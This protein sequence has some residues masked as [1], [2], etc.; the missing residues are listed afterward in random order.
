MKLR[1]KIKF[2]FAGVLAVMTVLAIT[3]LFLARAKRDRINAQEQL[4]IQQ[5]ISAFGTNGGLP[6]KVELSNEPASAGMPG[7]TA[8]R[9][10]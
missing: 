8:P 10:Q 7:S 3:G 5:T 2:A 1:D 4:Q 9:P 6:E